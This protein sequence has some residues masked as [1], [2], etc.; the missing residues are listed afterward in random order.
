MAKARKTNP[1]S[2]ANNTTVQQQQ[3][4]QPEVVV[5]VAPVVEVVVANVP[6]V[7]QPATLAV[8]PVVV[9]S[10]SAHVE[11]NNNVLSGGKFDNSS[12]QLKYESILGRVKQTQSLLREINSDLIL[13]NREY[14][15]TSRPVQKKKLFKK[16]DNSRSGITQ[17]VGVSK[18]LETFLGIQ[19]GSKISRTS[20]TRAVTEYI[21]THNLQNPQ[22]RRHIILDNTLSKLLNPGSNEDVTYFN[23]QKYLK[24]HYVGSAANLAAATASV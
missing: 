17:E 16:N 10:S 6:D 7:P 23:L 3:A 14:Q 20:V 18:E 24:V 5:E 21:K 13:L 12:F 4:P 8:E 11:S 9:E 1:A 2:S 22:N 19:P 15:R